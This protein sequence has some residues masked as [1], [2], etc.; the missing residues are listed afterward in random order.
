MVDPYSQAS[1]R[2][3]EQSRD[4]L[5]RVRAR[6][7]EQ[8]HLFEMFL[9]PAGGGSKVRTFGY[10][11]IPVP[12]PEDFDRQIAEADTAHRAAKEALEKAERAADLVAAKKRAEQEA[13]RTVAEV[14]QTIQ[15]FGDAGSVNSLAAAFASAQQ[16]KN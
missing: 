15:T 1:E 3:T 13:V 14:P 7:N 6:N 2:I 11:V 9:R 5:V 10:F 4:V 16:K 12:S 8:V